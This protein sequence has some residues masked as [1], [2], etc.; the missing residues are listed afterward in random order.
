MSPFASLAVCM[1][2]LAAGLQASSL[3]PNQYSVIILCLSLAWLWFD[4]PNAPG[5]GL[6]LGSGWVVLNQAVDRLAPL[7]E[8]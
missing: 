1:L 7:I 8:I 6:S 2:S 5:F 3:R 4:G